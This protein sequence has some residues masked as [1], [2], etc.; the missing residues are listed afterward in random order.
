MDS[1]TNEE[2]GLSEVHDTRRRAGLSFISKELG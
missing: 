2:L 1:L